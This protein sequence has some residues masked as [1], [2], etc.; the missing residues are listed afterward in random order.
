VIITSAVLA[1]AAS[2]NEGLLFVLGGGVNTVVRPKFPAQLRAS[3]AITFEF[4]AA[5]L[6]RE[7][8]IAVELFRERAKE[9]TWKIFGTVQAETN[10][11]ETFPRGRKAVGSLS[12]DLYRRQ[13]PAPGRYELRIGVDGRPSAI[14]R[15]H[16]HHDPDEEIKNLNL[17]L[18]MQT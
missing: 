3:L 8:M 5:D 1:N 7:H 10:L 16:A 6:R 9:P 18:D 14:L 17:L 2:V 12:F 4:A 11:A 15:F 13:V